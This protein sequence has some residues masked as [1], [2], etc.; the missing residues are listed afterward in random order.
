MNPRGHLSSETID[1]LLLSALDATEANAAKAH[2]D[3]CDLCKTRWRELNEDKVRFDG[4]DHIPW[5]IEQ[6]NRD[7]QQLTAM[8]APDG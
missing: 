5:A 1:L 4:A 7:W 3:E 2:L 6:F 8:S